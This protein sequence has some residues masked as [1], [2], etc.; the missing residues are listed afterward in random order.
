[1]RK[2]AVKDVDEMFAE[3]EKDPEF[4]KGVQAELNKLDS[5]VAVR[6]EREEY[7]WTQQ[8]LADKAGVP[9]STIAR[10]ENGA[11]TSMD[12]M[13]KIGSAF[14]KSVKIEFA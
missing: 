9:Q 14:G 1:M 13:S 8:E 7:G 4:A 12:T 10:I 5:A 3:Y 11:N 2:N 6:Q